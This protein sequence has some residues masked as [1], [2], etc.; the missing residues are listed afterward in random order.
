MEWMEVTLRDWCCIDSVKSVFDV[1]KTS[2]QVT[3]WLW[4][5]QQNAVVAMLNCQSI[6]YNQPSILFLSVFPLSFFPLLWL[7]LGEVWMEREMK[8][9]I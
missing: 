9:I 1:V 4:E 6:F 5:S 2:V 3:Q 7:T 8:C